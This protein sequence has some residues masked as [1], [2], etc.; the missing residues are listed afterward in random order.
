LI[1]LD[2]SGLLAA[3]D[4]SQEDH[5]AA[6]RALRSAKD[7][8]ILSP[9]VLAELDYMVGKHVG[10]VAQEALLSQVASGVYS[11]ERFSARDVTTAQTVLGRYG[12]LD[13]GL[14]D[15][16]IVVL[17]DRL[18]TSTIL[19]LDHRHFRALRSMDGKPFRLLPADRD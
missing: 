19:T 8:L 13:L 18:G 4:G 10:R 14:A 3:I 7:P 11:L 2:T 5:D 6:S 1:L 15:A 9:F 12:D 17:A 16:S